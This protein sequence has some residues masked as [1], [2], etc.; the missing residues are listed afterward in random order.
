[1]DHGGLDQ[2]QGQWEEQIKTAEA[3]LQYAPDFDKAQHSLDILKYSYEAWK[4]EHG[5]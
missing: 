5:R 2:T 1:L 4:K 3:Q